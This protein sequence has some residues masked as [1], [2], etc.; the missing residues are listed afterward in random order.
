MAHTGDYFRPLDTYRRVMGEE[1]ASCA[2]HSGPSYG[3]VWCAWGY[4]RNFTTE[5]VYGTL[6]KAKALGFEWAVL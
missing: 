1:R 4:E 5:Q 2:G 3:P 6:P